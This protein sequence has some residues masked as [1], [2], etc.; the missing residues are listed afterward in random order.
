MH[1]A[2]CL[3]LGVMRHSR[4][5]MEKIVDPVPSIRADDRTIVGLAVLRDDVPYVSVQLLGL[6]QL[7]SLKKTL[8]RS[9]HLHQ[10]RVHH[11]N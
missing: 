2:H 4:R 6:D 3:V 10:A 9:L 11:K 8:V 1:N 5:G 7:N